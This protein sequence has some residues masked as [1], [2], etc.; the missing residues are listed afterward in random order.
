MLLLSGKNAILFCHPHTRF[1]II[2]VYPRP[3][4]PVSAFPDAN[5]QTP[6][7]SLFNQ[8]SRRDPQERELLLA[9]RRNNAYHY[10]RTPYNPESLNIL[11]PGPARSLPDTAEQK[12]KRPPHHLPPTLGHYCT[13]E[14]CR[15]TRWVMQDEQK[16]LY[17]NL[18]DD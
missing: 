12:Q 16:Y 5:K 7:I 3:S 17:I 8:V 13:S 1:Y 15:T 4:L 11:Y 2:L 14:Y 18:T 9:R 6:C 10:T